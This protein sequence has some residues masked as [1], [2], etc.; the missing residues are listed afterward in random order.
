MLM[1]ASGSPIPSGDK[2]LRFDEKN[3]IVGI[4]LRRFGGFA[5]LAADDFGNS[6]SGNG[7]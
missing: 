5:V 7:Y 3:S 1:L 4:L 2:S 6:E